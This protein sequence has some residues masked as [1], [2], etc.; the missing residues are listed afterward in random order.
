[1]KYFFS[2]CWQFD[3]SCFRFF[4]AYTIFFFKPGFFSKEMLICCFFTRYPN[5]IK[6]FK[7]TQ[8]G[9]LSYEDLEENWRGFINVQ[10]RSKNGCLQSYIEFSLRPNIHFGNFQPVRYGMVHFLLYFRFCSAYTI[11]SMNLVS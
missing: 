9:K 10:I 2:E 6:V 11:F 1:M 4:S 8:T 7:V 3:S 5:P